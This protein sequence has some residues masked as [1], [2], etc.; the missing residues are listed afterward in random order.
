MPDARPLSLIYISGYGRS[1]STLLS[2][3]LDRHPNVWVLGEAMAFF[4]A[5]AR[6]LCGEQLDRCEFWQTIHREIGH[7]SSSLS[8]AE[9]A[10]RAQEATSLRNGSANGVSENWRV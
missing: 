8:R 6:C 3:L 9:I 4:R 10:R 5:N 1:G 2:A 7:H